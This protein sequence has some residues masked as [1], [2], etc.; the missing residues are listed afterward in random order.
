LV[1]VGVVT[2]IMT[3]YVLGAFP[4]YFPLL[5]TLMVT[6][7]ILFR[8]VYYYFIDWHYFMV[9]L[10]SLSSASNDDLSILFS[11]TFATLPM[12]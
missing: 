9:R 5:Y 4:L 3:P 1:F 2:V 11:S 6:L 7:L 10:L 8:W 12:G